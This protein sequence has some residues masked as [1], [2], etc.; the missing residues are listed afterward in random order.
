MYILYMC[1]EL[2][3]IQ[4]IHVYTQMKPAQAKPQSVVDINFQP[5]S[6]NMPRHEQEP[7][8]NKENRSRPRSKHWS[9][10]AKCCG[11]AADGDIYLALAVPP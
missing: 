9:F 4:Y 1:K 10:S 5:T 6:L 3:Y 11:S 8:F 2:Q 7:F